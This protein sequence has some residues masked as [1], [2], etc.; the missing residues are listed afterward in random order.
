MLIIIITMGVLVVSSYF[1]FDKLYH[2]IMH[3]VNVQ[4]KIMFLM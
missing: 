3:L 4:H 1:L 2:N